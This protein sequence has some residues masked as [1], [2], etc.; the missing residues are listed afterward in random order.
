[1]AYPRTIRG[2]NAFIDGFGYFGKTTTAKLP[3][4]KIKGED[5]RG[6]GMDA[7]V[8]IDMGMDGMSSEIEFAEWSPELLQLFGT[9]KRLILRPGA[10][11]EDSFVADAYIATIGGRWSG[12]EMDGLEQGKGAKLK[13]TTSV[14]YYRLEMNGKEMFEIDVENGKRIIGGT[15]Q[16]ADMRRA[17]GL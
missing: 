15:D 16:L 10:L 1:M 12:A 8:S 5:H 13:L 14:D 9:K 11:G 6:A 7:P 2:Y 4:L 17:M 3:V